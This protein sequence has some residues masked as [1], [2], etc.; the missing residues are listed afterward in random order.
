M[1]T[2]TLAA[3]GGNRADRTE[4]ARRTT[5]GAARLVRLFYLGATLLYLL[6]GAGT[7][8]TTVTIS[9]LAWV[10]LVGVLFH[11]YAYIGNDVLDLP[12]DRTDPRRM[13][14]PL[15][16]GSVPPQHALVLALT[17][18]PLLLAS[19]L[20]GAGGQAAESLITAAALIGVYNIVGKTLLVPFAAD[21]VQ[22]VG[23]GFLVIAGADMTGGAT[24][25]TLWAAGVVAV[26]IT[27]VNGVHGAIRDTQNDRRVGARTTA[28]MLGVRI[29]AG[30]VVVVPTKLVAYGAV[31]QLVCG[32]L[33]AGLLVSE[34]PPRSD[35]RW[36]AAATATL[37]LYL[38][39]AWMLALAYVTRDDLRRAMKTGTWHLLL[40]PASLL[41]AVTCCV[42][43]W[44]VVAML[45]SF[46]APPLL[47]GWAVRGTDF[48]MP[49]STAVDGA[50]WPGATQRRAAAIWDMTRIGTPVAA[51]A[52]VATGA[53]VAGGVGPEAPL[54][55]VALALAIA[56][57]NVYND[58][59]D[60]VADQINR[61]D[62]PLPAGVVAAT[63]C[64]RFVMGATLASVTIAASI[65]LFAAIIGSI[66]LVV[67]L[68]YSLVLRRVILL[69]QVTVAALFAVPLLYGGWIA[70]DGVRVEHWVATALAMLFVFAR[71]TLKAVPDS[72]GDL[73]A[74]YHTIATRFGEPAALS[75]FR[76]AA[77]AFCLGSLA[78]TLVVQHMAYFMAALL[79]AVMPTV[80]TIRLV[81]GSPSP[82]EINAAISFS[83]LVFATGIIPVLLMR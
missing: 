60:L 19:L 10:I 6:V 65:D 22:G 28:L 23:W 41:A 20:V 44:A 62:R 21:V 5:E 11:A 39:S 40:V 59:C 83:G 57:A 68:F 67:A 9:G 71:E 4:L 8:S 29:V 64:D 82:R 18:L 54:A 1:E 7:A 35:L 30:Q 48:G 78:A 15:V 3:V 14:D 77:G 56:A 50:D 74:G 31:L 66:Y 63:D 34:L 81:K 43:G 80:H 75:V 16:R 53:V 46:V 13:P 2:L 37:A 12:I 38:L 69:G 52:M 36:A 45:A 55:M 33:L 76:T 47:F 73:A 42:P 79:C 24:P 25:A 32:G 17:A 26:Y 58:R 49:S 61:P 51:A 72:R 27:M 70:A